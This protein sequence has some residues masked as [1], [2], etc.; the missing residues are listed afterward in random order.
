MRTGRTL[1]LATAVAGLAVTALA[2]PAHGGGFELRTFDAKGASMSNA[3]TAV[4]DTPAAIAYNPAGMSQLDG[5]Q[6]SATLQYVQ[7]FIHF[8]PFDPAE[9][10]ANNERKASY[11]PSLFGTAEVHENVH[12]GFGTFAPFGTNVPWKDEWPGRYIATLTRVETIEANAAASYKIPIGAHSIA[13]AGGLRLIRAELRLDQALDFSA[14]GADDGRVQLHGD[15]DEHL[16]FGW[17]AGLLVTLFDR[18]FSFGAIYRSSV[19]DVKV[20]GTGE[21]YN[22]TGPV[23]G[24]LPQATNARTSLTLP[25]HFKCGIA[26]R[27][28]PE[29]TLSADFAW[30]N[31]SR[32]QKILITFPSIGR[33]S[34]IDL[35]WQDSYFVAGGVEYKAIPDLLAVRGGFFWDQTPTHKATRSP[36]IPDNSRYGPS[37]GLGI[38]PLPMLS[39]DLSYTAIFL[40]ELEK[41]NLIGADRVQGGTPR[42]NGHFNTYA[43]AVAIT[44][45]LKF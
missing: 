37:I 12:L 24:S 15:T 30:T 32:L 35:R 3:F 7:A 40:R 22:L 25:D 29:L 8:E 27:P 18:Y 14:V 9:G 39:I 4:A 21:F 17:D 38:T 33:T 19:E 42:A 31:W 34:T 2:T 44:F 13:L 26:V 28:T 20:S 16:D 23:T 10:E 45:G 41:D 1:G 5:L 43:Q 11:I 6:G 36:S